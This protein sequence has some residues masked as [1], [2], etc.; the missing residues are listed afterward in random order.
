M[1]EVEL[2]KE[3]V[4]PSNNQASPVEVD[5]FRGKIQLKKYR[6]TVIEKDRIPLRS[7]EEEYQTESLEQIDLEVSVLLNY[8]NSIT[9]ADF[10]DDLELDQVF[11]QFDN[12]WGLRKIWEKPDLVEQNSLMHVNDYIK[13]NQAFLSNKEFQSRT[14]LHFFD[15]YLKMGFDMV[16]L[17]RAF[18]TGIFYGDFSLGEKINMTWDTLVFF[19]NLSEEYFLN[20]TCIETDTICYFLR[21]ICQLCWPSMPYFGVENMVDLHFQGRVPTIQK[22]WFVQAGRV[23][24]LTQYFQSSLNH[25]H[26]ATN[27]RELDFSNPQ[28]IIAMNR[29][30]RT[31]SPGAD[32]VNGNLFLQVFNNLG[33]TNH[34]IRINQASS[35]RNL[36]LVM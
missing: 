27:S 33:V 36:D 7:F 5:Y 32:L 4:N 15:K 28:I 30:L 24:D 13:F 17:C 8:T 14:A 16:P 11:L 22:A 21:T 26:L 29:Y 31:V 9:L 23:V 1:V 34:C 6:V 20:D 2:R 19:E 35:Y 3:G 10:E 25:I 18:L 12:Y